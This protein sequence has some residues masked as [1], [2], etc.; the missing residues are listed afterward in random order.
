MVVDNLTNDRGVALDVFDAEIVD[1]QFGTFFIQEVVII[2][3][4]EISIEIAVVP[5]VAEGGV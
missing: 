5:D 2:K 4:V 3:E 1:P